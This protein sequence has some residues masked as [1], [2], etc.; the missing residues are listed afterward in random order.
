LVTCAVAGAPGGS[1]LKVAMLSL[2]RSVFGGA[3]QARRRKS[4]VSGGMLAQPG[5]NVRGAANARVSG[6]GFFV[7]ADQQHGV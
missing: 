6:S 1:S 5:R 7:F 3:R 2:D 4:A